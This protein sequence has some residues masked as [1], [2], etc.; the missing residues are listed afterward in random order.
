MQMFEDPYLINWLDDSAVDSKEERWLG[1]GC[2]NNLLIVVVVHTF[3]GDNNG[4]EIT[5]IISAR[6]AVKKEREKYYEYR[7][8]AEST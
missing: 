7:K 1:L 8:I 5:R 4:E 2:I 3:R 6:R